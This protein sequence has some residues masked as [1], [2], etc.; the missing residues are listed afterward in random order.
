M[1]KTF[2]EPYFLY[3][4]EAWGHSIKSEYDLIVKLQSKVL[5]ILFNCYRSA[6]AWNHC[7][8][9]I[10]D[11]RDLYRIVIKK[12][13]MKHH[14]GALPNS[15]SENIMP[16][17]NIN[18]LDNKISRIS[19]QKMYDYKNCK[20]LG[21]NHFKINCIQNWNSLPFELKTIPYSSGKQYLHRALKN[22]TIRLV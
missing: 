14:F 13:C 21:N 15:F 9:Q 8:G 20:N 22:L 11:I 16:K 4:I 17:Q 6:D 5:R 3:A 10:H 7:N 12:M 18:Q 2:I 1:Y 19:L